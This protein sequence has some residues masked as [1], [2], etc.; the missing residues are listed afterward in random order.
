MWDKI[1]GFIVSKFADNFLGNK[2]SN[3]SSLGERIISAG[4]S[5]FADKII[6]GGSGGSS[7]RTTSVD[8]G[9]TSA[10]TYA[11]SDAKGPETPEGTDYAAMEAKWTRIARRIAEIQDTS[12][13]IG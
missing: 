3:G 12:S 5:T 13:R 8:L 10:K 7:K 11:M 4:A 6:G 2:K 9:V 1:G